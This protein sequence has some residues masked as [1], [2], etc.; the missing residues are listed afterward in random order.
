MQEQET[1]RINDTIRSIRH[2]VKVLKD[3]S[4]DNS[5]ADGRHVAMVLT[6][7]EEAELL[8]QRIVM[9]HIIKGKSK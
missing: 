6:K 7:L 4:T 1:I 8:A 9:P 3:W 5:S 2:T